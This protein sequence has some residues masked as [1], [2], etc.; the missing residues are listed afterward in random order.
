M[1]ILK[2]PGRTSRGLNSFRSQIRTLILARSHPGMSPRAGF[3]VRLSLGCRWH[4]S[5]LQK[6]TIH[7]RGHMAEEDMIYNFNGLRQAT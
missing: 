1:Y 7:D 6:N 4:R 3:S 2:I 5:A